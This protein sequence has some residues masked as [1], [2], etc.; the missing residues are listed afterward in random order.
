MPFAIQHIRDRAPPAAS[1]VRC[2]RVVLP[3]MAVAKVW[4]E[5]DG[6]RV[7][8][9]LVKTEAARAGALCA[10]EVENHHALECEPCNEP[11]VTKGHVPCPGSNTL[12]SWTSRSAQKRWGDGVSI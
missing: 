4:A 12:W 10:L 11:A 8:A 6:I 7:L 1:M 9:G 2:A 3:S 5:N